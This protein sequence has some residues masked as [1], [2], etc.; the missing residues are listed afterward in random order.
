PVVTLCR[1][2]R[3]SAQATAILRAAGVTDCANL[4]G[5]MLRW[6]V[7]GLPTG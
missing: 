6:N 5:G 7:L 1:S 3:R 4:V 2:G